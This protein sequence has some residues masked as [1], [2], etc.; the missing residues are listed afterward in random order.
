MFKIIESGVPIEDGSG[1]EVKE[2]QFE[3][4][5]KQGSIILTK[6]GDMVE[7]EYQGQ[8]L[9]CSESFPAS[10]DMSNVELFNLINRYFCI[11]DG[12]YT[13]TKDDIRLPNID[14]KFYMDDP[15]MNILNLAKFASS[16]SMR[17]KYS[18]QIF[19][20]FD[21]RAYINRHDVTEELKKEVKFFIGLNCVYFGCNT[22]EGY[23]KAYINPFIGI[24]CIDGFQ[25]KISKI[26]SGISPTELV[27]RLTPVEFNKNGSYECRK[28]SSSF[29]SK[30]YNYITDMRKESLDSKKY[31]GWG[32][33]NNYKVALP[34]EVKIE[35]ED[36]Y[37]NDNTSKLHINYVR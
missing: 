37:F 31:A 2:I 35:V 26:I 27:I 25:N 6:Y 21:G 12:I 16:P 30:F 28:L 36:V 23:H 8:S 33:P 18:S 17:N 14:G 15:V 7:A 29:N 19:Y 10:I 3:Y 4:K 32:L 20:I 5:G 1:N 13:G 9:L 24:G 22:I 34:N 11:I